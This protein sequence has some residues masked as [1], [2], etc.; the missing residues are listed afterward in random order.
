M[1]VRALQ[2]ALL[3]LV[4]SVGY[5]AWND[6]PNPGM[7]SV[8]D[9]ASAPLRRIFGSGLRYGAM[10]VD[11]V[12]GIRVEDLRVP[13]S[14]GLRSA[15][16]NRSIDGFTARE[17]EIRQD[18]VALAAG[19]LVLESVRISGA[20]LIAAETLDGIK[21]DFPF[22]LPST[23]GRAA[24]PPELT[25][26]DTWVYVRARP[27]SE[28]LNSSAVVVLYVDRLTVRPESRGRLRI[29]GS[30][31]AREIEQDDEPWRISGEVDRVKQTLDLT[32][33]VDRVE[34]TSSLLALLH[35]SVAA[36]LRQ[37][38]IRS[39]KLQ[40]ALSGPLGGDTR[41]RVSWD[42][43][44][45]VQVE[46]IPGIETIEAT[47]KAQLQE[48]FGRGALKLLV[49]QDTVN[50]DQ[51]VTQMAGGRVEATGWVKRDTGAMRL[52]F[53]IEDLELSD[54]AV[55]L[56]L[57]A[58][59]AA[60]FDQF[61][62]SGVVDAKGTVTRDAE[63]EIEWRVDVF[64]ED[65]AFTFIGSPN[66]QG[67]M[68]GFPYRVE[69]ATGRIRLRPEGVF[70]DDV[71]GFH[72]GAE[73]T[74]RGHDKTSWSGE[75]TGRIKFT[76][77]GADVRLTVEIVNM[78]VDEDLEAAVA[79]SE[80]AGLLDTFQ[81]AGVIDK[82]EVDVFSVPGVDDA[83]KTS[84]RLQLEGEQFRYAPFPLP[85][86]DVRGVITMRRPLK[87][88]G[89]GVGNHR[90]GRIYAFE[91]AGWAE[92]SPLHIS[93]EIND[94]EASGRIEINGDGVPLAGALTRTILEAETTRDDLGL[95]WRW[96][97]P[98]GRADVTAVLPVQDDP[99]PLRLT[100]R[101]KG[102]SV[103]LDAEN[104]EHP[105]ELDDLVGRIVVVDDHV[106][107]EEV[108]GTLGG[109]PTTLTGS[110]QGGTDGRW[111]ITVATEA[112]RITPSLLLGLRSITGDEL[113]PGGLSF[114]PGG[115]LALTVRLTKPAGA[116]QELKI[117]VEARDIDVDV[118]APDAGVVHLRGEEI[119][120]GEEG[121]RVRA[122]TAQAPG[123][124][125]EIADAMIPRG[126]AAERGGPV[127]RFVLRMED[128][129]LAGNL[130]GLLPDNVAE[131]LGTWTEDR[132]L[133]STGL[134]VI[135]PA[136]GPVRLEGPLSVI[137][138]KGVQVGDGP[139]GSFTLAP[140]MISTDEA[141]TLL[142]GRISL[143]GFSMGLGV[144][145]DEL[146][147]VVHLDRLRL[148]GGAGG[149]GRLVDIRGRVAGIRVERLNAPISWQEGVLR[150]DPV[151]GRLAGGELSGHVLVH[152]RAPSAYEGAAKIVRFDVAALQE[153]IAPTGAPLSG[154]GTAEVS[155]QNRGGT[156]RTLTAAGNVRIRSGSLGDLP[157]VA[158][159]FAFGARI[160][161]ADNRP[162]FESADIEF[163]LADEVFNFKRIDLAGPLFEMP[164]RGTLD[165][166]GVV[167]LY[168]TPDFIKSL[169]LPG[170]M[171]LPVVGDIVGGV[172]REELLYAVRV[173]GELSRAEPELV[174]LPPLGIDF[175]T[176]FEGT[177]P[178]RLPRRPV[179]RWFR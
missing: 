140:L 117:V 32:I 50:I 57:G 64:L 15:D 118:R 67:K 89:S 92:G 126:A 97:G 138:P 16:P 98:R 108:R 13:S 80:F 120:V 136:V 85:L 101:L 135:A 40:V 78:A 52:A 12:D 159:I 115:T 102:A 178:R 46:D 22:T 10:D 144:A 27:G 148:G 174:P 51:L 65:A 94:T 149:S 162:K 45:E 128:L 151:T 96:L 48:L 75:E 88:G 93:A 58:E 100:T 160:L 42:A 37:D 77:E 66:A 153:D 25:L 122:V 73:I 41:L 38:S 76:D 55:R 107:F 124:S 171:Q 157:V 74:V 70:F 169:A 134:T 156:L 35:E 44:V 166:T 8:S 145:L 172:L 11:V 68:E 6:L 154:I 39:G 29:A 23:A 129:A 123:L 150:A 177:G 167:D 7:V 103:R 106:T 59:G 112:L 83:A 99:E 62:P 72:R 81:L 90:R 20:R 26:E 113:L 30:V 71:V 111:D 56:A 173:R 18:P 175:G 54:P 31:F 61:S 165:T 24:T 125:V 110:I 5:A 161:N 2:A 116:D 84:V 87:P 33:D 17:V 82:I 4:V 170:V 142:V 119:H 143:Q 109:S 114:E 105:L 63:G 69:E 131:V 104:A 14:Q 53:T 3:A 127:G 146:Y 121:I 86:E 1:S 158:N 47:T 91:V 179:P 147:G 133:S 164:G 95:V 28:R 49:D 152:T 43:D 139:R 155:F 168:F 36:P 19:E 141:G 21:P 176:G 60:V 163:V 34:L 137:A 132:L 130:L 79:G 9:A